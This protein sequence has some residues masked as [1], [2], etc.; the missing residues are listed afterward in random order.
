MPAAPRPLS[1]SSRLLNEYDVRDVLPT[2]RLPVLIVAPKG[3]PNDWLYRQAEATAE[4]IEGA[5]FHP[6]PPEGLRLWHPSVI[7]RRVRF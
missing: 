6:L 5:V 7:Q 2:L 1:G 3:L 4:L